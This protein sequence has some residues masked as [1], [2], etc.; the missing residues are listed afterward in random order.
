MFR[1]RV[2][3][4]ILLSDIEQ[5]YTVSHVHESC[6]HVAVRVLHSSSFIAGTA[7]ALSLVLTSCSSLYHPQA[8][9]PPTCSI[10]ASVIVQDTHQWMKKCSPQVKFDRKVAMILVRLTTTSVFGHN[11]T[12]FFLHNLTNRKSAQWLTFESSIHA[13]RGTA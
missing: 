10:L 3:S 11:H 6:M 4:S 5:A 1:C 13:L 8:T 7:K 12:A 9:L 2:C